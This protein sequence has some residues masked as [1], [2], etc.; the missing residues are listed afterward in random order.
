ME[1][2]IALL[3]AFAEAVATRQTHEFDWL[4]KAAYGAGASREDLLISVEIGQ[5]VGEPPEPVVTEASATAHLWQW[6]ARC[7]ATPGG[8]ST[9]GPGRGKQVFRLLQGDGVPPV[10]SLVDPGGDDCRPCPGPAGPEGVITDCRRT[11]RE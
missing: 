3:A 4:V 8:E 6:M 7:P 11:P 9:P 5:L 10:V 1:E 2:L